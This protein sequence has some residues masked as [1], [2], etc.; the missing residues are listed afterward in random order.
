MKTAGPADRRRRSP[1]VA[2][3]GRPDGGSPGV[4]PATGR[5]LYDT[6]RRTRAPTSPPLRD[7]DPHRPM[8]TFRVTFRDKSIEM[9]RADRVVAARG[10]VELLDGDGEEVASWSEEEVH[11]IQEVDEDLR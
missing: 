1:D 11:A 3:G 7:L 10:R 6:V 4:E 2:A 5:A 9:H 8:T